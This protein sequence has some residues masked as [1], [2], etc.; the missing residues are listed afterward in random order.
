ML[1]NVQL[2]SSWNVA[3]SN[4]NAQENNL[5]TYNR[6]HFLY[7]LNNEL[8]AHF[9]ILVQY[10]NFQNVAKINQNAQ[11]NLNVEFNQNQFHLLN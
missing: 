4:L 3:Q 11:N 1:L 8:I 10:I 2:T 6:I 5:V 7:F 9:W